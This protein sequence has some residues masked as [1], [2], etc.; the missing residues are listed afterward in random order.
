MATRIKKNQ[1]EVSANSNEVILSAGADGV[2]ALAAGDTSKFLRG[3]GA[4]SDA[5]TGN[6]TVPTQTAGNNSTRIATTAYADA[7]VSDAIA[8]AVT[9]VAPSQN[10]V[11]DALALKAPL[12]SPALT[13][14]PTATTQTAGNN[15][16]RI[17]TTAYADAKVSDAITD[18]VT[19]IAPSQNAVFDALAL[20]APLA[21][22]TFTGTPLAPTA[23]AGTN[24]TQIATTA[25]VTTADNLKANLASPT[26]T[27]TPLAPTA[28]AGTNNTQIATTAYADAK[29]ADAINDGTTAIA[30]S[31]NAVFDALALKSPLASPTF[32]GTVVVPD[33]TAGDNS[34]KA[35]NTKYVEALDRY[36]KS[37]IIGTVSQLNGVPTGAIMERGIN[38][39]GTYLKYADGTM[40]CYA[41]DIAFASKTFSVYGGIYETTCT[42]ASFPATFYAFSCINVQVIDSA[43]YILWGN[44]RGTTEISIYCGTNPGTKNISLNY[45]AFGRWY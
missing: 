17:A 30:P 27:G 16:T 37:N 45:V 21:S 3:D 5:L 12:A 4:W 23:T 6:P 18:A 32:T 44:S 2:K 36:K 40:I 10:A 35:A 14:N 9:G 15:S 19:G 26:L 42:V 11:F 8:D 31:Q 22:P 39:A 20:K 38:S 43:G 13:G 7:K 29:V 25:F 1:I 24:T 41:N 34:T 28:V 33:Q